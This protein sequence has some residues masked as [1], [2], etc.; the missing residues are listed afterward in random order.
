M[1]LL[2]R[3]FECQERLSS[4]RVQPEMHLVLGTLLPELAVNLEK[5]LLWVDLSLRGRKCPAYVR[6]PVLNLVAWCT[7]PLWFSLLML[8]LVFFL[9]VITVISFGLILPFTLPLVGLL[10]GYFLMVPIWVFSVYI[11][12]A[13]PILLA[14]C[15]GIFREA[16]SSG[17]EFCDQTRARRMIKPRVSAAPKDRGIQRPASPA[18]QR[19]PDP[20]QRWLTKMELLAMY[21]QRGFLDNTPEAAGG[22]TTPASAMSRHSGGARS[23][24][25]SEP[26]QAKEAEAM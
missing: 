13:L 2:T 24:A 25:A 22:G 4:D 17:R 18:V 3:V 6:Y 16:H 19:N 12:S 5:L 8:A 1:Q 7:G 26:A 11:F 20:S 21:Q 14:T 23:D 15:I 10:L 9:L